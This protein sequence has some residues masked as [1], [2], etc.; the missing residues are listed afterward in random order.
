MAREFAV[1]LDAH[2]GTYYGAPRLLAHAGHP[3]PRTRLSQLEA[4]PLL[5][6]FTR[7]RSWLRRARIQNLSARPLIEHPRTPDKP[8]KVGGRHTTRRPAR[9]PVLPGAIEDPQDYLIE[10]LD[11]ARDKCHEEVCKLAVPRIPVQLKG[12]HGCQFAMLTLKLNASEAVGSL[13]RRNGSAP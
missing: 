2:R 4:I 12:E 10:G 13:S 1:Q 9:S 8:L 6:A 5:T 3:V 11:S 7:V